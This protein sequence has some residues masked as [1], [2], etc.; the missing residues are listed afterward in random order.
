METDFGR[1]A[2]RE[3]TWAALS[4]VFAAVLLTVMKLVI[5]LMTNSLGILAEAAHS[6]LDLVAA[7]VTLFAVQISDR[8]ADREHHYGHGKVENISALF[9]TLLLLVTCA[10]IIYE[11]VQRLFYRPAD[12]DPSAWAFMTMAISIV[13]DISR[14]RILYRA[15]RKYNSQALE[16]DG[17]HFSTDVWS[18]SV[19]ILGLLGV[20]LANQ[21]PALNFLLQAD[22][23]AALV[24]AAIV[25]YVS[26]QL[27]KRTVMALVDTAP[28]GMADQIR[29]IVETVAGVKNCH[30]VRVR[31]AGAHS[32][33]DV[34]ILVEGGLDLN[35]V[36]TIT[37]AIE[38]AVQQ[39]LPTID[40]TVHPEPDVPVFRP[41]APSSS[42]KEK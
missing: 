7:I 18:S 1:I 37:E 34:H 10:W 42:S 22:A 35:A 27:G 5:G 13:V 8:P 6:G 26:M 41:T 11:A 2:R 31:Y 39:K 32:F 40:L 21:Y 24:V 16:A 36:H 9:E 12:V 4:S 23:V 14:S 38:N 3:K 29:Q 33:A 17:L 28:R 30:Q 20:V 25:I 19:V 15:A